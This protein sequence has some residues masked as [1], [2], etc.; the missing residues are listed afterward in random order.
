MN[1]VLNIL[2]IGSG[3]REHAIVKKCIDSPLCNRVIAAPGNGGMAESI[4]CYPIAA[5][6][7]DECV[8]LAKNESIDFVIVGPE[9][10]LCLGI[11]DALKAVNIPAYGPTK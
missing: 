1:K 11:V 7:I 10:P 3:G 2:V 6:A 9:V 5:D 8:A 4:D